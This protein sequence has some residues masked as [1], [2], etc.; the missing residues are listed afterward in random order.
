M[1]REFLQQLAVAKLDDAELLFHSGRYSN[2]YYL[3]GYA[4]EIALK[5]RIARLFQADTIP[6]RRFVNDI[7]THDLN[8]L[9][10][11]AGLTAEL[12]AA[13]KS[14]P[15][16]DRFCSTVFDWNERSRYDM[17]DVSN[18]TAMRNAMLDGNQGVFGWLR[19]RW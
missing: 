12:T 11:L 14:S 13:R 1:E 4:A 18:A 9:V 8:R 7:Y 2:A 5:A 3:F 6:D 10:E 15:V 19:E 17:I 16:L